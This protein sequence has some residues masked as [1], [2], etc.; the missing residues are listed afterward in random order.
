MDTLDFQ[1]PEPYP[2]DKDWSKRWCSHKNKK[3]GLHYELALSI[4]NGNICWTNGPFACG[5]YN[6]WKIF[7][8]EG[9]LFQLDNNERVKA[10]DGYLPG[11]PH[12]CKTPYSVYHPKEKAAMR[13][14]VMGRQE[15]L[16][17]KL[18]EWQILKRVFRHDMSKHSSV[19]SAIAVLTQ[20]KIENGE[21]LYS[22]A[23]YS[24][25]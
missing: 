16:N 12:V 19:F 13:R 11:D 1:I 15:A 24:D 23:D 4:L 2:F 22:C 5:F 20:L 25:K 3:A 14:R 7:S 21:P 17:R 10:D 8:T 18:R 6:D 9:L